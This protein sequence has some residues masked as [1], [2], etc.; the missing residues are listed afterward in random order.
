MRALPRLRD[1]PNAVSL[2]R[3]LFA[4]GFVVADGL[5]MRASLIGAASLSD[6]LDG[7][8]ARRLHAATRWGALIDPFADRV[9]VLAAA[10][11]LVRSGA[12]AVPA[13]IVLIARD[14]ATA[15]GFLVALLVPR[16]RSGELKARGLGKLVTALQFATLLAALIAPALSGPFLVLVAVASAWSIVDY[17]LA[18]WRVRV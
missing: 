9:F 5:A 16:L 1:L 2:S 4:A 3:L 15:I 6:V 17:A 11:A 10:L 8:L 12:L 13:A 7:W 18:L 14:I